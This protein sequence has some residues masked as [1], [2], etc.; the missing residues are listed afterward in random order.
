[1]AALFQTILF[2]PL[3]NIFVG[4]YNL[5]PDVGIVILILTIIIKLALY[6]L[7]S[8]SIKSQKALTDLQPKLDELK[9]K[10]KDE[11][12]KVAQETMKMYKE[13][14]VNPFASCLPLLIQLPI[15][16]ALYWVLRQGLTTDNFET[17]YSFVSNPGHI[18]T[19]SL[20]FIE[21]GKESYVLALLA[22][23]AQFWQAKMMCRKKPPAGA[24]PGAKDE[25]MAS[26]MNKQMLY[27]MPVLTVFIGMKLPGGLTLY[28][29][30]STLFMALQQLVVFNKNKKKK[31]EGG[32]KNGVIEGEIV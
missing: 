32:E 14:K 11:Q 10:Y 21:L 8:S 12:Q 31:S 1:M 27:M 6:P 16:I 28:W 30:L 22:G 29:F 24:G 26:M 7:T 2:Q 23:G 5:I 25:G 18:N 20:G 13:N 15:L 3:F 9:K 17:L 4:L 19:L